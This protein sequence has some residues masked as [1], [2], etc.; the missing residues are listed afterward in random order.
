M[1]WAELADKKFLGG[2]LKNFEISGM[3]EGMKKL[4]LC[5]VQKNKF[6]KVHTNGVKLED[7]EISTAVFLTRYGMSIEV[8]KPSNTPRVHSPDFLIDGVMWETKSP[9]GAGKR[10]IERK[11]HEASNQSDRLILDLRRTKWAPD[12]AEKEAVKQFNKS[13]RIRRMLI[14][15]KDGRLLDFTK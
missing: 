2:G 8:M 13:R 11:F 14:V 4:E 10:N 12:A 1:T 5:E 15:T 3:L 9:E 7:H 6:G